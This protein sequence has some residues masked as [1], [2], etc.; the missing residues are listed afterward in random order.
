[1]PGKDNS[2]KSLYAVG[3][4][5][6]GA[7]FWGA[8][9][10]Q[11]HNPIVQTLYTADPAP[12]VHDG[13]L[14]VYASHDEHTD[15]NFF[16]MRD[17]HLFSTTDLVNWTAHGAVASLNDLKW[18]DRDNG[19]WAPH[20]VER[21]GKFYLYVP[22]H[23]EGI[24]VLV[25]DSPFGPFKDPL[26]RRFIQS[27]NIWDDI[28]P[29]VL[30]DDEGR[31]YLYWGNPKL[32][33]VRLNEDMISYDTSI[34]DQGIVY[35][36][37]T[38]DAFGE[39]AEKSDKYTTNYEEGPW[40]W[41]GNGQY[42]LFFAAGGIPE[43]I[44]YST[45]PT[46]TGPW[47]YRGVVMDRH[48][49]LSFTNHSG[50]VEFKGRALFFYHN[51]TLPG[52]GGFNRSVCV[53]D[54]CFNPDGSVAPIIPTVGGI[55]EAIGSLSPYSRVEAETMAWSEGIKVASDDKIGVYV[56]DLDDG[57]YIK[58]RNV[59]FAQGARRFEVHASAPEGS[60]GSIE[61]RIGGKDGELLGMCHIKSTASEGEWGA[62]SC[63]V[64][65]VEGVHDLYLVFTGGKGSSIGVDWWSFETPD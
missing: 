35:V 33:Y 31:A 38:S 50:V 27:A 48:P 21:N 56:T 25:A 65:R 2:M 64:S 20:C 15:S 3:F 17:W 61:I 14:Y 12:M 57:D 10:M 6:L 32:M 30:L 13:T 8:N 16:T 4:V 42:Y 9:P 58:L 40:L 34:G 43:V 18:M 62:H 11:A 51:E 36:E 47:S 45:A 54:L 26:G 39:R 55:Q 5:T 59:A 37:M 60:A 28:D 46:A 24:G 44:A 19:A 22:I 7:Y 63:Q 29:T 23:G 1:M 53:E 52:G 49:G 41:K